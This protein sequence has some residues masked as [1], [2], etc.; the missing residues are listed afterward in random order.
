MEEVAEGY[1]KELL[2]RG[3]ILAAGTSDG[4]IKSC[5]THDILREIVILKSK[6]QEIAEIAKD[7][8]AMWSDKVR[9]LSVDNTLKNEQNKNLFQVAFIACI[10]RRRRRFFYRVF[11][12][13]VV[14][15]RF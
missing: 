10:R 6:N 1:L 3:L 4:R 12:I 9:C 14:S 13:H 5:R 8:G 15:Q 2:D 11:V 7:Q